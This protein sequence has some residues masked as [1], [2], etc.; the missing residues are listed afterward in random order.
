MLCAR[1]VKARYFP[2]SSII[3]ATCPAGGG[4][5]HSEVSCMDVIYSLKDSYGILLEMAPR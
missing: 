5:S 1:V 3:N 2:E 4:L